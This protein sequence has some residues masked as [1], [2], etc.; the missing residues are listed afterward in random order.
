MR[1]QA[2]P[3]RG[4][5]CDAHAHS[6]ACIQCKKHVP[7]CNSSS[8]AASCAPLVLDL[9]PLQ[10]QQQGAAAW[11]GLPSQAKVWG[12]DA[13]GL[14]AV[15]LAAAWVTTLECRQA[16]QQR[17]GG[18]STTPVLGSD[19]RLHLLERLDAAGRLLLI[20]KQQSGRRERMHIPADAGHRLG[21]ARRHHSQGCAASLRAASGTRTRTTARGP[22]LLSPSASASTPLAS[23]HSTTRRL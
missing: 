4:T 11:R 2:A 16:G 1:T 17:A 14:P 5:C 21:S 3:A 8:T 7:S 12:R 15:S 19:E 9:A 20:G 6:H 22:T 10:Q 13:A 23:R 18:G